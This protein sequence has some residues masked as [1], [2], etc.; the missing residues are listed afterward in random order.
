MQDDRYRLAAR[1]GDDAGSNT[2]WSFACPG[3]GIAVDCC[4]LLTSDLSFDVVAAGSRVAPAGSTPNTVVLGV[5]AGVVVRG[6]S[7]VM[8]NG[9]LSLHP[10]AKSAKQTP[11]TAGTVQS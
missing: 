10:T 6:M 1:C 11:I 9:I 7:A 4:S 8:G 3:S 5:L 2:E